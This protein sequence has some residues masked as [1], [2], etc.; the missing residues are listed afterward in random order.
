M[1]APPAGL[2]A[3]IVSWNVLPL[4]RECLD[5]LLPQLRPG[6]EAVV[7]DN[8]SQDGTETAVATGYPGVRLIRA[9]ANLGFCGGVNLGLSHARGSLVL[10]LN[11]DTR[12]APGA[13]EAMRR[14]T[15]RDASVAVV[16]PR[17]V[18]TEGS[19]QPSRR[20]FPTV[21]TLFVESTPAQRL[22][23]LA[24]IPRRFRLED[25]SDAHAQGVDWVWGACFLL[26]R[27]ALQ[28]VGGL[29]ETF[30]MYSEEV[31]LCRRLGQLGWETVFEPAAQ[32][33]H[34]EGKSSEQVPAARLVRFNR[35]KVLYAEKHFGRGLAEAL[36]LYLLGTF[37]W[38]MGLEGTKLALGHRRSLRRERLRLYRQA[39]AS[40]LR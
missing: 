21:G 3:V 30:F 25:R 4:L 39:L 20:R 14:L 12:L 33:V 13:L 8:A 32:V 35:S 10:I 9:G 15:D 2:S 40:G 16:G 1:A 37:V 18:D 11:P 23:L 17:L 24:R 7:V 34:H 31:D 5:S 28:E 36:R 26:R 27:E 22:P 29:D 19:I 38:E 6:D